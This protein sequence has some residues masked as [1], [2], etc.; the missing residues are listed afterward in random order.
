MLRFETHMLFQTFMSELCFFPSYY[1]KDF[2]KCQ[3]GPEKATSYYILLLPSLEFEH[4]YFFRHRS[5]QYDLFRSMSDNLDEP[6]LPK[7]RKFKLRLSHIE[8]MMITKPICFYWLLQE[9]PVSK[10]AMQ[11]LLDLV[12]SLPCC[13]DFGQPHILWRSFE[14]EIYLDHSVQCPLDIA[15]DLR[16]GG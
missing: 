16:Q 13:C 3:P 9:K 5:R 1:N 4:M 10:R 14:R 12:I 8:Y 7:L 15:T 6:I 11:L 2:L